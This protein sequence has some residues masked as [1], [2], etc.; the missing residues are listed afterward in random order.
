MIHK[1]QMLDV[2]EAEPTNRIPWVPRLDLWYRANQRAGTLPGGYRRAALVEMLDD[3][4]WGYHA[5]VPNFQD[6]R[7]PEDDVHR[8]LGI[9]NLHTMPVHTVFDGVDFHATRSGDRTI[10]EYRTPAGPLTTVTFYDDRMRAAGITISHVE[11]YPFQCP[12]DY[13]ALEYL[14]RHARAVPN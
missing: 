5:V 9:V 12:Q 6:L 10:V 13:A 1:Q 3:L 14:F 4:G 7:S 8:G 2:L 11:R